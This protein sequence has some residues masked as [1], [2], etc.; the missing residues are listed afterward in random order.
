MFLPDKPISTRSPVLLDAERSVL[1]VVDLQEGFAKAI[2]DLDAVAARTAI[3]VKTAGRL[4]V[5]VLVT[6]QYPQALGATLSPVA[7]ALP[8]GSPVIE[9]IAFSACDVSAWVTAQRQLAREGRDQF[10]LCGVETHVCVLQTALD[11][12]HNPDAV[13]HVVEDAVSSR[14]ATD[15]AAAL[16]RLESNGVQTVTAEMVVFEWLRKA[17][18]EDFK[19]IQRLVK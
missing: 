15:K 17:G 19:D 2:A 7:D 13:V 16:R 12:A 5:P 6:E 3:L 10:I 1:V 4:G 9:K 14:K 18:T 8:P 11:L